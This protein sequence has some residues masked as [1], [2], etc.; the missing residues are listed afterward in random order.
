MRV[1]YSLTDHFPA[2]DVI[3]A[4]QQAGHQAAAIVVSLAMSIIGGLLTGAQA[5]C[6]K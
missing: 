1:F 5:G 2:R 3:S 6:L 4:G